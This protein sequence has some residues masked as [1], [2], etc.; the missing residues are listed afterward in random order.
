MSMFLAG[1]QLKTAQV[2]QNLACL[3]KLIAQEVNTS[4]PFTIPYTLKDRSVPEI[5]ELSED[6]SPTN[7]CI[8]TGRYSTIR[9][10]T[11]G[12][13]FFIKI[14]ISEVYFTWNFK[15][16]LNKPSSFKLPWILFQISSK[17]LAT[18]MVFDNILQQ[19]L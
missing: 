19:N 3:P 11:V 14:Y 8:F 7:L 9:F 17:L 6:I 18:K 13:H 1:T 10:S 5:M 4:C 12:L 2:T 15:L 16:T